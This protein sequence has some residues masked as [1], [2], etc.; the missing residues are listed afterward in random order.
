MLDFLPLCLG[1]ISLTGNL[2]SG[3]VIAITP[4]LADDTTSQEK[5]DDT[6]VIVLNAYYT[7]ILPCLTARFG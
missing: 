4:V 6:R 5:L 2:Q 3:I 1:D 7:L